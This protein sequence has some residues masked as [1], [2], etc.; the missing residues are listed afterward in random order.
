MF[1]F[2]SKYSA[3]QEMWPIVLRYTIVGLLPLFTLP[4]LWGSCFGE[5][6][7]EQLDKVIEELRTKIATSQVS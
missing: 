7:S 2:A 4:I 3:G 5:S 1:I 6:S